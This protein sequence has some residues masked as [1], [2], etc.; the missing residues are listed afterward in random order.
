M[1]SNREWL[2]CGLGEVALDRANVM[3]FNSWI[4]SFYKF[5]D[6]ATFEWVRQWVDWGWL[7]PPAAPVIP[8]SHQNQAASVGSRVI[9]TCE[10]HGSPKPIVTWSKKNGELPRWDH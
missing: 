4:Q 5:H 6:K 8:V 2:D 7:C 1:V 10:A 9:L 3:T